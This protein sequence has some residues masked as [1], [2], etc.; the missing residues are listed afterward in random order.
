VQLGLR[1]AAADP[2]CVSMQRPR[3]FEGN[4][5][6]Q[7]RWLGLSVFKYWRIVRVIVTADKLLLYTVRASG[8][9]LSSRKG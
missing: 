3:E 4:A 9:V 5:V 1:D 7:Q 2:T 6:V 8:M